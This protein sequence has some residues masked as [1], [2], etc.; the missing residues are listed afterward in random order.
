M[1]YT[2]RGVKLL[3]HAIKKDLWMAFVDLDRAFDRVPREVVWWALRYLSVDECIV[4]L[5]KAMYEDASTKVRMNGRVELSM[6]RLG[7]IRARFSAHFK[8]IVVLE[9]LSREFR[10][11]LP[12]ELFYADDHDLVLNAETKELLLEKVRKWKEWMEKKV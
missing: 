7:C 11:G 3:E 12:M 10:E 8:F 5:I 9:A 6:L 1:A 2:G 4:S